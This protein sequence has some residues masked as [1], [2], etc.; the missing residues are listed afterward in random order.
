MVENRASMLSFALDSSLPLLCVVVVAIAIVLAVA[1][2][3][4]ARRVLPAE[5]LDAHHY[6]T[7]AQFQVMGTIYAV[8]LAFVIITVWQHHSAITTTLA[9]EAGNLLELRRDAG[10]YPDSVGRPL[11][12]ALQAYAAA[13]VDDEWEAMRHGGESARAE[14]AYENVWRLYR[15]LPVSD[16][17]E[18][19]AQTETLRR[20]NGLA[21]S[22]HLRLLH[23]RTTIDPILWIA[24]LAGAAL[25]IGFSY[26]FGAKHLGFQIL[27]TAIFAG[28]IALFICV[29]VVLDAPFTRAGSVSQEPFLRVLRIMQRGYPSATV[30]GA[31]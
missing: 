24:L 4:V 5:T 28:T 30:S 11:V 31:R 21:E 10:Q 17:R 19:A 22:R 12:D 6:V 16:F 13:V 20:M 9:E 1:G 18:L 26:L 29:I 25:T 14:A 2:L 7:S 3:L 8:L 23:A 27:T 15:T